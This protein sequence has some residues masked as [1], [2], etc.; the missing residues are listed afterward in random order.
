MDDLQISLNI[1]IYGFITKNEFM[2]A[3]KKYFLVLTLYLIIKL[4]KYLEYPF[5]DK[6]KEKV[7]LRNQLKDRNHMLNTKEIFLN[8][9]KLFH[10]LV[11]LPYLI[12]KIYL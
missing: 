7:F 11:P 12:T 8:V 3:L 1:E 9:F 10:N 6:L 2:D 4:S 5:F